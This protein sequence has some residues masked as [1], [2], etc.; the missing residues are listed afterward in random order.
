MVYFDQMLHTYY[1]FI[2]TLFG[3]G[4]QNG[5]DALS[6]IILAGR[7]ILFKMSIYVK[8]QNKQIK[9]HIWKYFI[10]EAEKSA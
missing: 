9:V 5:G 10:C 3:H 2:L 8:Q 1:L 4:M 6:N 7:G